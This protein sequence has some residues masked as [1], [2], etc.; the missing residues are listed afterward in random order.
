MRAMGLA[1]TTLLSIVPLI[2]FLFLSLKRVGASTNLEVIL[3]AFFR[4]MGAL[5]HEL[6]A[7]VMQ[8]VQNLRSDVLGSLGFVFL[9][10][11]VVTTI[12]KVE[13]SFQFVWRVQ[14]RRSL[15]RRAAE[16]LIVMTVG[17]ILI[18]A[19]LGV[20]ASAQNGPF[21]HWIGQIVP[22]GWTLSL[23]GKLLP[24]ALV[25]VS[26]TLL[27]ALIPSTRVELRAAV[28][29]GLAAGVL[30]ALV[31][32]IFTAFILVSSKTLAIYTGFAVVLT[33][34]IWVYLSWMIFLLG[35]Q[36]AFYVQF[37]NYLPVGQSPVVLAG[38]ACEQAAL[39]V[40]VLI[41]RDGVW[42][43][44]RLGAE[45]DLPGAALAPLIGALRRAGLVEWRQS[46]RLVAARAAA[47]ITLIEILVAVRGAAG[48]GGGGPA[49]G[50][51]PS[52]VQAVQRIDAALRAGLAGRTLADLGT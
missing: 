37:P 38:G 50:P 20:L 47:D 22:L 43:T 51:V 26:F 46:A 11:T 10:Y 33:T 41:G 34:L 39:S 3:L 25:T 13:A 1:Y 8:S 42:T 48:V 12:Q 23:L 35:A 27:Y 30:W 9:I 7:G 52:V 15:A 17:P 31:G 44:E 32:K 29:G 45:L 2:A 28:I 5:A 18:G 49:P 16:Y 21:A 14:N 4:P 6:T 24:Y 36:L 40:M 19:A